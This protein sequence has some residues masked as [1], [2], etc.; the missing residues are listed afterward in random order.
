MPSTTY[1]TIL[2]QN[3]LPKALSLADSL[4]R[5]HP[6]ATLVVVL[7]DV[8]RDEDLPELPGVR[9]SSTQILGLTEREVLDLAAGYNLVEFATAI[10]PLLFL[11]LLDET[12]HVVYLDP[13]TYVTAPMV[14]LDPALEASEGGIVLT[15]HYLEPVPEGVG[16]SEGH[17]LTVGV[18]NLGFCAFDQRA[19]PF[20][21]WWWG[22]LK[23]ECLYE[24][25][26]GLFVDQKWV[27][28]GST[29][30]KAATLWH[31]GYNVGIVNLH[32]RPI[33]IDAEGYSV[34]PHGERLR[35]FHFH[36]F[37]TSRPEELSTRFDR[38]SA[39]LRES[40]EAV[41]ALCR[42]YAAVLIE[43]ERAHPDLPAYVYATDTQGKRISRQARRVHRSAVQRG[44]QP[45]S[46]FVAAEAA[47]YAR[48]HRKARRQMG[49]DLIGD[50][51]KAFRF[52]LPD[53][54]ARAKK[55]F[56]RLAARGRER[57]ADKT[58]IWG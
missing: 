32:E 3:Y 34:G 10:K 4:R 43:H 35:L 15:P 11:A 58:G 48:W 44:E 5:H 47:A 2:A 56:P 26:S 30:F 9:A 18:Y 52:A 51:A 12:D 22:H 25:F 27:D 33:H 14:E 53:E 50:A 49:R 6:D 28:V 29:L 23:D 39:H 1:C 46:P 20:L 38:S 55:R 17:L 45:P 40:S 7:I 13:D 41:D 37:D 16:S 21:E 36:S 24:L 54:F 42:E 57:F 31:Y 19:R 8:L